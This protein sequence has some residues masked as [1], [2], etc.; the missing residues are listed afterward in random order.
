MQEEEGDNGG[1]YLTCRRRVLL[2]MQ[3]EE[4]GNGGGYLTCRRRVAM[5]NGGGC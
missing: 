2:D 4:G 5:D 1:G 3:E